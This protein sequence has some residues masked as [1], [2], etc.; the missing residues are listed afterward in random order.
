MLRRI[1]IIAGVLIGGIA[2]AIAMTLWGCSGPDAPW[3]SNC[4]HNF[5]GLIVWL[6]IASWFVLGTLVVAIR[7]FRNDE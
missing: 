7:A 1:L 5:L 6:S 4:G 3:A 2:L